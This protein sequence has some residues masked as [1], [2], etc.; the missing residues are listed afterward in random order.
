MRTTWEK[1]N[2]AEKRKRKRKRVERCRIFF[3]EFLEMVSA[4]RKPRK[5]WKK[6]EVHFVKSFS[7]AHCR[8]WTKGR[9]E[10]LRFVRK[11]IEPLCPIDSIDRRS[12]RG[13]SSFGE[14][15]EREREERF[16]SRVVTEEIRRRR[17]GEVH[18]GR[19]ISVITERDPIRGG[20]HFFHRATRSWH[21][22]TRYHLP[23]SASSFSF[24]RS[25]AI[26]FDQS[27]VSE[28]NENFDTTSLNTF[29]NRRASCA[30]R[31]LTR[32]FYPHFSF[33]RSRF[34]R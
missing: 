12:N 4:R 15:R 23:F 25:N 5:S 1:K 22:S 32:F 8:W 3:L 14:E 7:L 31:D 19:C 20:L 6:R 16:G 10:Q 24:F 11:Q 18:P 27:S 34:S 29:L 26:L 13:A 9:H 21:A 28:I 33:L 2:L 30:W 17:W